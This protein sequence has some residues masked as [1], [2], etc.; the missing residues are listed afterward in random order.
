MRKLSTIQIAVLK[1]ASGVLTPADAV[2]VVRTVKPADK[3]PQVTASRVCD[4]LI[5][6]RLMKRIDERLARRG[7]GWIV[8]ARSGH[9]FTLTAAG[10]EIVD[11]LRSKVLTT[12]PKSTSKSPWREGMALTRNM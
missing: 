8:A 1:R 2:A 5:Q 4:Q 7:Q 12:R 3:F 11:S 6:R 10:L 9:S